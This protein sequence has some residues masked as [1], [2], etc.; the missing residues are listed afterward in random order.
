MRALK[1]RCIAGTKHL[2][3]SATL[4]MIVPPLLGGGAEGLAGAARTVPA[5]RGAA[6]AAGALAESTLTVL[7]GEMGGSAPE[8]TPIV[9][10][11]DV[12]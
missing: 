3:G 8:V 10:T 11:A 7:L 1:T 12:N 5:G 9:T 6:A 4:K 2:A